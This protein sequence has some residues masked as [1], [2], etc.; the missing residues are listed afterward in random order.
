MNAKTSSKHPIA[1]DEALA[2]AFA[3]AFG[4]ELSQSSRGA[5]R[6]ACLR[7]AATACRGLLG[8]RWAQTQA[9]DR[10]RLD[11]G[12]SRRVHYLSMEFLMGRALGNALAALGLAGELQK[13][14]APTGQ[15][16]G[17]VLEREPDAALGNGGLGRL[18]ACFLDS[19]AEL[20]VPSFGYGLR[21]RYGM[22]AQQ[23]Q[24]GR[25]VEVPDAWMQA[26]ASWDVPR[27][28]LSYPV[29]FGGRVLTEGGARRWIPGERLVAEA[30]DFIVPAHRG[31]HVST[32]RQW[33]ARAEDPIDFAAFSRG[34]HALAARLQ[35][36]AD[37]LNWVLYPDDSSQAGRELRLKQEDRKSTRLNSSHRP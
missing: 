3:K 30:F 27:P 2:E 4:A 18:A 9:A 32:L 11:E 21:Y 15:D 26:G 28:E 13:A 24:D 14:L 29:G 8:E 33:Q 10:Q 37:A 17:G 6:E 23:I 5:S 34:D 12:K 1:P 36:Q 31:E 25:Q 7:A 19:F 35:V 20:D 22:F 16:L